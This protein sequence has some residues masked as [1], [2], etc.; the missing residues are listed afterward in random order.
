MPPA[1]KSRTNSIRPK[2]SLR[3]G[4]V[5][6]QGTRPKSRAQ[7]MPARCSHPRNRVVPLFATHDYI[8]GESFSVAYCYECCLHVTLPVPP[9]NSASRYY[10]SSYYGSGRRFAGVVEWLLDHLHNYRAYQIEQHQAKGKVLDIGCGRGLLLNKLRQRGWEPQGTELSEEAAAYARDR[11]GL[12]VTTQ[13]LEEAGFP[14]NEF[15]LVILWHVLEHIQAPRAMLNEVARILKPGG[16]LL[17]AVPNLGSW[18]A[19]WS[20]PHWFHLDVPR[21]LTHFTRK[22]LGDALAEAGLPV[23]DVNF[24]STE[25]DFFSFV[26]SVQNKLGLRHNL[27]YNLL[28]TRSAKVVASDDNGQARRSGWQWVVALATAVPLTAIS[29]VYAPIMA[30][31]GQGA[32]IAAYAKKASPTADRRPPSLT[33]DNY[34]VRGT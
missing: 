18:E 31:L 19:R 25:Y 9:E 17:V 1:S 29:F 10:P 32:T 8:T 23:T 6:L 26:Q 13:T 16:T 4:S 11:L 5:T 33:T 20:G 7:Y 28:R 24:F 12:P 3:P 22:T 14:D 21:H 15:D 30:A 27:L 34:A 2:D